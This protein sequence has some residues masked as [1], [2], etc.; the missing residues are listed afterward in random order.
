METLS[1]MINEFE[2]QERTS[3]NEGTTGV[4]NLCRLC[5][6]L[7]YVDRQYF[8]QFRGASYGDLINFMED[9]SGAVEAI[10]NWIA[11]QDCDEWRESLE[12]HL[13]EKDSEEDETE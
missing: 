7:G 9:N 13:D 8:G 5:N 12:S 11:D 6:A 4:Q 2:K 1:E 10:K 3:S